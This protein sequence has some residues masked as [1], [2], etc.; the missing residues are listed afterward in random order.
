MSR[1][2]DETADA[3][4]GLAHA[5]LADGELQVRFR[6]CSVCGGCDAADAEQTEQIWLRV[7]AA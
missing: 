4:A 7:R 6:G 2:Y 1:E 3:A 5:V